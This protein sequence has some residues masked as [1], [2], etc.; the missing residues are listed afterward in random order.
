[1]NPDIY[2][3]GFDNSLVKPIESTATPLLY[4]AVGSQIPGQTI[5]VSG[6][7]AGAANTIYNVDPTR[8]MWMG[9]ALFDNAPFAV[10]MQGEMR[11]ASGIFQNVN[12][13]NSFTAGA[14]IAA[15]DALYLDGYQSDGGV[16]LDT[17]GN[18]TGT[19]D[20]S[21]NAT[22]TAVTV[23]NNSNRILVVSLYVHN[24]AGSGATV[25]YAG[26]P[27]TVI[28]KVQMPTAGGWVY[29]VNL[30]APTTGANNLT[31]AGMPATTQ[32]RYHYASYYNARQT[33][34]PDGHA[35]TTGTTAVSAS[36]TP[37]TAG[38]L[39]WG[40]TFD[41]DSTSALSASGIPN[42]QSSGAT[43][44]QGISGDNGNVTIV[45]QQTVTATGTAPNRVAAFAV[46]IAPYTTAVPSVKPTNATT[47]STS[48]FFIGFAR[49][50]ASVGSSILVY[51]S[52]LVPGFT[53][54][55]FGSFYYLSNSNGA[56]A[57]TPGTTTRKVG[58]ATSA[59]TLLLTNIW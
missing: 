48:L 4:D 11:A 29:T 25:S 5:N 31:V 56:I 27:C 33:S 41:Q 21:G 14:A 38:S 58:Q 49:S 35:A 2:T 20:G 37:T 59:T 40:F 24:A 50:S 45:Q 36:V 26:S 51:L 30:V 6:L 57:T 28:D 17:N 7:I 10:N 54:L 9:H 18:G 34:Q 32:Y 42:N 19:G 3:Y 44:F 16:T 53:A 43:L 55:T 13:L 46:S 47:N 12:L 22:L 39:F 52:G 8:G 15:N 1:M 23:G